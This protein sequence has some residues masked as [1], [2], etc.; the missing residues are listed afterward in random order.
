VRPRTLIIATLIVWLVAYSVWTADS[1]V[2]PPPYVLERAFRRLLVCSAGFGICLLMARALA[3]WAGDALA[4]RIALGGVLCV[5][6]SFV[7]SATNQLLVF[8][9]APRWGH[10][11]L[12]DLIDGALMDVWVFAAWTALYLSLAS[13]AE[14][15]DNR[16]RLAETQALALDAQNRML[17]HQI[18][19]HFM[20]NSLNALSSLILQKDTKR[21]EGMVLA[22]SAFLRRAIDTNL[23]DRNPLG[24]ELD[25][26]GRYLGI[27]QVRF[28]ER[29]RFRDRVPAELRGAMVPSLILQP[30]VENA[31]KHGV[32]RT[33]DEVTIE[34]TAARQGEELVI[35][36]RD[37]ARVNGKGVLPRLGVG[38]CN[39][40]GRLQ[41]LYGGKASLDCERL[42]PHGFRARL[43]L[44]LE[45]A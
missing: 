3:A 37:D 19:P 18:N 29:L 15:R 38:L 28:G 5:V 43:R 17:L 32:A 31:V 41:A 30:L 11:S 27:D 42:E 34:V 22:L 35:E 14:A 44:P 23:P 2:T 16:E 20:F 40:R 36:V 9:I 7:F 8:T 39:V 13:D 4:R 33:E 24:Y 21:A 10:A 1:L 12:V 45:Q 26:Q 25:E 6:A